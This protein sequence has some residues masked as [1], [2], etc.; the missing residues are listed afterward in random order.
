MATL[1]AVTPVT[2]FRKADRY[3]GYDVLYANSNAS[4]NAHQ[5]NDFDIL[6][7]ADLLDA[8]VESVI[9]TSHSATN[10][11]NLGDTPHY[12]YIGKW[13]DDNAVQWY[14]SDRVGIGS[15]QFTGASAAVGWG[16]EVRLGSM[17]HVTGGDVLNVRLPPISTTSSPD[18]SYIV[19]INLRVK[20]YNKR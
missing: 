8:Y 7:P 18:G 17:M 9:L 13:Y 15:P 11:Y 6:L 10:P 16:A 14:K 19:Y 3:S 12:C 2:G 20:K 1:T 5:F 4:S